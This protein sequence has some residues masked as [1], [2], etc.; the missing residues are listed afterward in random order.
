MDPEVLAAR[1]LV[2]AERDQDRALN[3]L[4]RLREAMAWSG[5]GSWDRRRRLSLNAIDD[6]IQMFQFGRPSGRELKHARDMLSQAMRL[7]DE[8]PDDGPRTVH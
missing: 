7:F 5:G 4:T 6:V 8:M 2:E 3:Y 1:F